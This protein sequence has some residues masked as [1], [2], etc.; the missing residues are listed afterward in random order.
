ME[1]YCNNNEN[2]YQ[3]VERYHAWKYCKK[4]K[5]DK[6]QNGKHTLRDKQQNDNNGKQ[7]WQS[8]EI[9]GKPYKEGD[10]LHDGYSHQRDSWEKRLS[11]II[12]F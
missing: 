11:S 9:N 12:D 7:D 3:V 6:H 1:W 4:Y 5:K 2:I 10:G 8:Y